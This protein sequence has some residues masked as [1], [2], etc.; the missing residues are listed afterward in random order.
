[1]TS[2]RS[3]IS[4]FF[5]GIWRFI[6]GTRKLVLNLVF[7]LVMFVVIMALVDSEE[8]LVIE[9]DTALIL[10]PYGD[11]V[12]Q[13]SGTPLDYVLMQAAE[14]GRSETRLRD[15]VEA[16]RRAA[17]DPRIVRLVIDPAF[18]RSAGMASLLEIEDAIAQFRAS[19]KPVIALTDNLGQQQYFLAAMADKIWLHPKGMVW[20]DGFSTYRQFYA[21]GL[22]K[23][24]IEVNLFRAGKYKS[25]MEPFV[26]NDMSPE[27]KEANLHWIGDLWYQYLDAVSRQR[28]IP[29]ESLGEAI[30]DFANRLEAVDGDFAKFALELGL[31]DQLISRPEANMELARLGAPGEGSEGFRQVDHDSYL[32]LT[33][34]KQLPS[35][36]NK[37]AVL[38]AEGEIVRGRQPQGMIGAVTLAEKLRALGEDRDVNA[39]VLRINSPGGDAFASEKIR[40]EIQALRETGKSVVVSMGDVAASGGYWMAMGAEQVWAS[41][42]SITGSIGVFGMLPTFEKPLEKMGIHSDGVGTTELAGKMRLDRSLDPDLK[43]IFQ[44]ATDR[45][46]SDFITLVADSRGLPVAAVDEVA[47]G[48]VWSGTQAQGHRLVDSV[49]TLQDSIDAAARLAGLGTDYDVIYDEWELSTFEAMMLEM[50]GSAM[51]RFELGLSAP[52]FLANTLVARILEDLRFLAG[53]NEGLTIAAHCLCEID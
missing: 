13:Y 4:R 44:H 7:L 16:V 36:K 12:E 47:Q 27:A 38:V 17:D 21:E 53:S 10:R 43:R 20:L 35:S 11:V 40:R 3:F 26:R 48:R 9:P 14:T 18:M 46:Y 5:L 51:V 41:P 30:D 42:A 24:E 37:V 28:A 6:D 52:P 29:A 32:A 1:M 50:V 34:L 25:A 49:G 39:V 45:T 33:D 23:L 31:V 8:T 22:E 15:L 19:G 2:E